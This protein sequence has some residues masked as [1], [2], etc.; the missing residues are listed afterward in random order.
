MDLSYE[1]ISV[2]VEIMYVVAEKKNVTGGEGLN[3]FYGVGKMT[4]VNI[5]IVH[6]YDRSSAGESGSKPGSNIFKT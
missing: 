3:R 5:E 6:C 4:Q 2:S 1:G